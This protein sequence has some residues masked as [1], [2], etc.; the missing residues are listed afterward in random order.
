MASL[1]DEAFG[2]GADLTVSGS[3]EPTAV[4]VPRHHYAGSGNVPSAS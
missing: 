2:G 3:I 1:F 4:T